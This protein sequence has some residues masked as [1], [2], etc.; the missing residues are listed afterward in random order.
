M[1]QK[2]FTTVTTTA[3]ML[4]LPVLTV[5]AQYFGQVDDLFTRFAGFI[6]N[7]LIPL[8]F[9]L[10]LLIFVWGMFRFFVWGQANEEDRAKGRQLIIWSIVGMAFMVSI[11]GIVAIFSEGIFGTSTGGNVPTLP[12][13]PT[14]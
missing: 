13:T 3:F 2:I 11:W 7:V 8:V 14:L 9:T 4:M 10:T 1:I 5:K 12:G 6:D